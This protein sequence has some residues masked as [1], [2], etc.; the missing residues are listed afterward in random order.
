MPCR[1]N[2]L[3]ALSALLP[4]MRRTLLGAQGQRAS[5]RVQPARAPPVGSKGRVLHASAEKV[6]LAVA[7]LDG[8]VEAD[9]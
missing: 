5:Q 6:W 9:E 1:L 7:K 8:Q 2:A 4:Q 3:S